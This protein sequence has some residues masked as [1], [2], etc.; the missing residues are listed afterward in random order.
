M[1]IIIVAAVLLVI[2]LPVYIIVLSRALAHHEIDD[3]HPLLISPDH[4]DV[5]RSK[6]LWVIPM[7]MG[8]P[9]SNYPNWVARVKRLRSDGKIIG[10]HGVRHQ[11]AEFG[12]ELSDEYIDSGIQEFQKAF[13][14]YPRYFKAPQLILSKKNRKKL[15]D[16][17]LKIKH[18]VNQVL[19]TVYH[20]PP[21]PPST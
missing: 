15:E 4:P 16:R 5:L 20:S 21:A 2:L 8:A 6:Y 18:K 1:W 19:H 10:L 9:I 17:G 7:Y 3:L 14:F 13:G 11:D 12:Q